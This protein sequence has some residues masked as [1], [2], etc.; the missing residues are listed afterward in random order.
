[1]RRCEEARGGARRS[2]GRGVSLHSLSHQEGR[3]NGSSWRT[4]VLVEYEGEGHNISDPSC[5]LLGPGV[6]VRKP[7]SDGWNGGN[8]GG[9]DRERGGWCV[10]EGGELELVF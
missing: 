4:D 6:S 9:M 7:T 10:L 2:V 8:D 3:V 1:M 5:P